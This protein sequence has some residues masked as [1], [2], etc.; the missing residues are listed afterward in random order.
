MLDSPTFPGV[1]SAAAHA[2]Q[3]LL[4]DLLAVTK[5]DRA[6]SV[7]LHCRPSFIHGQLLL[8]VLALM[9]AD[10][11]GARARLNAVQLGGGDMTPRQRQL[12]ELIGLAVANQRHRFHALVVEH[13][14]E[15]PE[16]QRLL[17]AAEIAVARTPY[18]MP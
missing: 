2:Y 11:D 4:D 7:L 1:D 5:A 9:G 15:Y 14:G 6:L 17:T 8:V 10:I 3:H 12:T 16:D 13:A 18:P